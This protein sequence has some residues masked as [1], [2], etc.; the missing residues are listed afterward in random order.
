[1]L[2]T[3]IKKHDATTLQIDWDDGH[4]SLYGLQYLRRQCPCASCREA[5]V[6]KPANPLRILSAGEVIADDLDVKQA[7]VVGRYAISFLW[8]D[9]H[10][11]GIY[12]F[13]YLRQLCQCEVCQSRRQGVA[14]E[15]IRS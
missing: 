14:P 11:T 6:A 3:N 12:S 2:P 1:M 9:G 8:S 5:R 10:S 7:E 13:D 15:S 4:V